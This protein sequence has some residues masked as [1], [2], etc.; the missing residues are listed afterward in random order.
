MRDATNAGS[1][2]R[3]WLDVPLEARVAW[4]LEDYSDWLKLSEDKF[5][6]VFKA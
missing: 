5:E 6:W 2:V 4:I 3:F 1:T